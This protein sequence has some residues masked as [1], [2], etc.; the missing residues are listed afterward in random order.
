VCPFEISRY[1]YNVVSLNRERK[2]EF[3]PSSRQ[4]QNLPYNTTARRPSLPMAPSGNLT[5]CVTNQSQSTVKKNK[6]IEPKWR[7]GRTYPP[8]FALRI[9]PA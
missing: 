2:S 8:T 6:K 5:G 3:I 7:Y 1:T 4:S 9:L